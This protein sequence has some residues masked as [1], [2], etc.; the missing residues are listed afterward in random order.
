MLHNLWTKALFGSS[1]RVR[2]DAE[3]RAEAI[4]VA[5]C[6][7]L[8]DSNSVRRL[9]SVEVIEVCGAL[10]IRTIAGSTIDG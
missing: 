8:L 10:A 7:P 6:D 4:A 2:S 3:E 1:G 5:R 9:L